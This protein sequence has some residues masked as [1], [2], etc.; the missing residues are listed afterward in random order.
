MRALNRHY[1][2]IKKKKKHPASLCGKAKC[3]VCHHDKLLNIP[4]RRML[5]ELEKQKAHHYDVP[6]EAGVGLEPT[7]FGL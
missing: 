3:F 7:V 1:A 6:L 5:R 4:D 2:K